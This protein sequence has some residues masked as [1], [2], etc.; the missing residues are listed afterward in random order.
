MNFA[1]DTENAFCAAWYLLAVM[2][3]DFL[4]VSAYYLGSYPSERLFR[5]HFGAT[6]AVTA[7]V[8]QWLVTTETLPLRALPTHLLWL[9]FLV[10]IK[11]SPRTLLSL[12]G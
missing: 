5:E 4:A 8:W 9:F 6:A 7:E 10:E 1:S 11:R 3:I 2:S 12:F